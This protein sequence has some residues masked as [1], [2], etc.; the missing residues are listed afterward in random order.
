MREELIGC[1]HFLASLSIQDVLIGSDRVVRVQ[2]QEQEPHR[3]GGD[4]T[5]QLAGSASSYQA[6]TRQLAVS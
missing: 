5:L 3:G 6:A 2:E 4:Q 1:F